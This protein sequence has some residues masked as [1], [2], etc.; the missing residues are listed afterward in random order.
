MGQAI[1]KR[2]WDLQNRFKEQ[3]QCILKENVFQ[4]NQFLDCILL[5]Q[6]SQIFHLPAF[7]FDWKK[8]LEELFNLLLHL[9]Y[10][11][12]AQGSYKF[13]KNSS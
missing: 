10:M 7:W 11:I 3:Y 1:E 6:D 2:F 13:C 5:A 9:E 12:Q 8:I 4:W